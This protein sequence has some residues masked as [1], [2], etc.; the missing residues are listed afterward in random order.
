VDGLTVEFSNGTLSLRRGVGAPIVAGVTLPGPSDRACRERNRRYLGQVFF[1]V[2]HGVAIVNV[3]S[4]GD[5]TCPE[6]PAEY[7]AFKLP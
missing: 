3:D 7:R 5:D 2:R 6:L 1:N 4:C